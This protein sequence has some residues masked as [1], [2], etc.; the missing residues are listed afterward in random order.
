MAKFLSDHETIFGDLLS[1]HLL[2]WSGR[3][4]QG[5][6]QVQPEGINV[7]KAVRVVRLP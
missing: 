5:A 6:F 4:I 7:A 1:D 2:N 3:K